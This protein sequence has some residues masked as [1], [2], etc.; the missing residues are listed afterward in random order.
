ME[1]R[2]QRWIRP[3][4]WL[5]VVRQEYLRD[6][7][8][9]GG[10]AVKLVVPIEG[11]DREAIIEGLRGLANRENFAFASL[12]AATTKIHLIDRLFH[13]VAAQVE[14]KNLAHSFVRRL[15]T[16][17]GYSLPAEGASLDLAKVAHLNE[18]DE[19]LLGLEIRRLFERN[20]F[21]DYKMCQEFRF[22]TIELCREALGQGGLQE[23]VAEEWLR[24]ELRLISA[25][26]PCLIFQKIARHNARHMLLSFAHWL[27]LAGK[28]GLIVALDISRYMV[29]RRPK[30]PDATLYYSRPAMFDAYEVIRQ[31]ID[32]TDDAESCFIVVLSTP[33]F[34][35]H[36]RRGLNVYDALRFRVQDEVHDR[37]RP[38]PLSTLIRISKAAEPLALSRDG[39]AP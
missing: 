26:K 21:R 38:N 35:N 13:A 30:E 7:I 31:L 22:A 19:K 37:R 20:L 11:S 9:P 32:G 6:F 29:E 4:D 15:L 17:E 8:R 18:R 24:G 10:A 1:N 16:Q 25:M 28:G 2:E 33:D 34:L 12:D 36:E 23:G 3:D 5:E 27:R 39:V 14:W